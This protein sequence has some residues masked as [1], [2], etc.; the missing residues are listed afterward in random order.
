ML[1]VPGIDQR[2]VI[3]GHDIGFIEGAGQLVVV[4]AFDDSDE[5]LAGIADQLVGGLQIV[6]PR[7]EDERVLQAAAAFEA[8]H[9]WTGDRPPV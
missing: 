2:P 1:F 3:G 9:P 8:A 7:L 4:L 6:G 5:M